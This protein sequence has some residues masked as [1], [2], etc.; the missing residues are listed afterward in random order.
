M[1]IATLSVVPPVLYLNLEFFM[2]SNIK[3]IGLGGMEQMFLY[4]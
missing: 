3:I 1:G 2:H 4:Q